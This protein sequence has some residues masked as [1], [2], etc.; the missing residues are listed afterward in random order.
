MKRRR[1]KQIH[2]LYIEL[3]DESLSAE[4][5]SLQNVILPKKEKLL[6]AAEKEAD[7]YLSNNYSIGE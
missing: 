7:L 2:E 4:K 5:K 1:A 3:R 6:K